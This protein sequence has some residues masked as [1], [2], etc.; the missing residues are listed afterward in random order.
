MMRILLSTLR[1]WMRYEELALNRLLRPSFAADL[2]P[3]N[4]ENA[5]FWMTKKVDEALTLKP[6]FL[7]LRASC[8]YDVQEKSKTTKSEVRTYLCALSLHN[9]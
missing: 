9:C 8:T 2:L 5:K 7:L 1:N 3:K 4:I 6:F